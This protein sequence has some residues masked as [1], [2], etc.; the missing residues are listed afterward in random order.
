M[1]LFCD[2][3]VRIGGIKMSFGHLHSKSKFSGYRFLL[4]IKDS[5]LFVDSFD[6]DIKSIPQ[7]ARNK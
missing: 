7:A 2:Q 6:I 5:A 4:Y 1:L 3:R